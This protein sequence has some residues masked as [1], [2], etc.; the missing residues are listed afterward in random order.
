MASLAS[1]GMDSFVPRLFNKRHTSK[2]TTTASIWNVSPE[3]L[4]GAIHSS[5]GEAQ[6][7]ET[8]FPLKDSATIPE[9]EDL[10][11]SRAC[12]MCGTVFSDVT[13][14]H[15]HYKSSWH[16][17]N[18]KRQLKGLPPQSEEEAASQVT[19]APEGGGSPH[20]DSSSDESVISNSGSDSDSSLESDQ[21]DEVSSSRIGTPN[22]QTT[23][24]EGTV[25]W[26]KFSPRDGLQATFCPSAAISC[27]WA[28]SVNSLLL[29]VPPNQIASASTKAA[30]VPDENALQPWHRLHQS[31]MTV[32]QAPTW[33][34]LILRSGKFAGAVYHKSTMLEHKTFRRYTRRG[35]AGG[36][37][38]SYDKKGAAAKS[39][40]AQMRRA[41]EQALREDVQKLLTLWKSHLEEASMVLVSVPKTMREVLFEGRDYSLSKAD[42]RVMYMP[43]MVRSPTIAEVQNIYTKC[44][45]IVFVRKSQQFQQSNRSPKEKGSAK[46]ESILSTIAEVDDALDALAIES[47]QQIESLLQ[48]LREQ[49]SQRRLAK[50]TSR[51]RRDNVQLQQEELERE[52]EAEVCLPSVAL[53]RAIDNGNVTAI[54]ST[55]S[56]LPAGMPGLIRQDSGGSVASNWSRSTEGDWDRVSVLAK[57]ENLTS[58]ASPLHYAAMH[59]KHECVRSLLLYGANPCALDARGRSTYAVAKDKITRDAFRRCRAE[60]EPTEAKDGESSPS[61]F[62]WD[63]D[64]AGVGPPLYSADEEASRQAAKEKEKARKKR[65]KQRKAE[66]A[67][68]DAQLA[69]D[70]ALAEKMRQEELAASI[71]QAKASAGN[72]AF[73]SKSLYDVKKPFNMPGDIGSCCTASCAMS[74]RRKLQADAAEKRLRG[75]MK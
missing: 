23:T 38:S 73:C 57:P 27:D 72:C 69:Q 48:S 74:A 68:K 50:R 51:V 70:A 54:N 66:A 59:G 63:W 49:R 34:V 56:A 30:D 65:A 28:F 62:M 39:A 58:L 47:V 14:Q 40:G 8:V 35:K 44:T 22:T 25:S 46:P 13:S 24:P 45:S 52:F 18:L 71:E 5:H 19:A 11:S 21:E 12:N 42:P 3:I 20:G 26:G 60:M 33:V 29:H 67:A 37:Q 64:S 41:G 10:R 4:L 32:S 2:N 6:G 31:L 9:S 36:A 43:F 75:T 15:N 53:F 16:Y 1:S 17:S 7:E 61:L 55:L